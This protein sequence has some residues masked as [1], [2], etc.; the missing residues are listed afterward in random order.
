MR[1][2]DNPKVK[3]L[4]ALANIS[5][6]RERERVSEAD[7]TEEGAMSGRG[8][9]ELREIC[10]SGHRDKVSPSITIP[11]VQPSHPEEMYRTPIKA[12]IEHLALLHFVALVVADSC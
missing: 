11:Y 4:V 5:M 2:K 10:T 1:S 3:L 8:M 6:L 9:T 7:L 12:G